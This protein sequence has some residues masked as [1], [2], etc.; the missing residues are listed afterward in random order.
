MRESSG[1][2]TSGTI[3]NWAMDRPNRITSESGLVL[4]SR[5]IHTMWVTELREKL[6]INRCR[7]AANYSEQAIVFV[8]KLCKLICQNCLLKFN[9]SSVQRRHRTAKRDWIAHV[10]RVTEPVRG[11][12]VN[13]IP[14]QFL[15]QIQQKLAA[16][17]KRSLPLIGVGM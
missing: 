15:H 11:K 12:Q 7:V 5:S 2:R 14:L 6:D 9:I 10:I 16:L 17:V 3:P 8:Q 1:I 4:C 13:P